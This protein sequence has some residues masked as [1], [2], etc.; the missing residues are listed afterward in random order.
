MTCSDIQ[1]LVHAYVDG[2]LD[3]IRHLA[4]EDHVR[5]CAS[6]AARVRAH[7]ELRA[8]LGSESFYF[9]APASLEQRV[10]SALGGAAGRRRSRF[11]AWPALAARA[12][13]WP[14]LAAAAA[15]VLAAVFG[16]RLLGPASRPAPNDLLTAELVA[17]HVRSLMP[18]H[19]TDVPS[20]DQH[21]V[22]PWFAGR[23]D[24][25]PPVADLRDAGFPLAGGRLDYVGNRPVAALVYGRRLHTINLFV[26]PAGSGSEAGEW[27]EARRGYNLVG[28]TRAGMRF[29]AVSDLNATELREFARLVQERLAQGSQ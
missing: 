5:D 23:L 3:L 7:H 15:I 9:R 28:W 13:A 21:T 19:L 6:C 8:A 24:F 26:W 2:E 29:C 27:A 12:A 20:S 17:S 25:S 1:P 18:G 4:V 10:R 14:S 16:W 11:A 22:K